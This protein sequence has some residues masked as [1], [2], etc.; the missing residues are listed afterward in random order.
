MSLSKP[1]M[2]ADG[3]SQFHII[4]LFI[5]RAYSWNKGTRADSKEILRR[6]SIDSLSISTEKL[7]LE[8]NLAF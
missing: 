7:L 8:D 1:L 6:I 3:H 2:A 4:K 5:I